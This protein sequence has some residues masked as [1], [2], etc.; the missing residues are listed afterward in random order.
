[1]LSAGMSTRAVA[2]YFNN[3]FS[4]I[5]YLLVLENL[6]VHP[7]G[8]TTTDHM[9]THQPE[10]PHSDSSHAGSSETSHRTADETEE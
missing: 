3:N 8:H 5:S 10:S 1:M 7:S 9:S 4:T 2:R 6:A